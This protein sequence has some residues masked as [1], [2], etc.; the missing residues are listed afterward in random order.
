MQAL[1]GE[2]VHAL[3]VVLRLLDDKTPT[4]E[5]LSRLGRHSHLPMPLQTAVLLLLQARPACGDM[6]S[7][8]LLVPSA[9]CFA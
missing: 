3:A 2:V 9:Q 7:G 6:C 4:A 8:G 1:G 5:A